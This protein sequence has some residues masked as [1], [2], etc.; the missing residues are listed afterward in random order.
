MHFVCACNNIDHLLVSFSDEISKYSFVVIVGR[1]FGSKIDHSNKETILLA[2]WREDYYGKPMSPVATS[3]SHDIIENCYLRPFSVSHYLDVQFTFKGKSKT[4]SL[5]Q[6]FWPKYSSDYAYFG[7]PYSVWCNTLV[8][9]NIGAVS[10]I[11]LEQIVCNCAYLSPNV[12][13]SDSLV[14]CPLILLFFVP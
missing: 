9:P 10:F 14:F 4:F 1:N 12:S 7:K 13:H 6:G 5:A 2:R 11:S 8:E 3:L